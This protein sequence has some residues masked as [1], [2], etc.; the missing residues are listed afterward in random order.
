MSLNYI[1]VK[2]E[3][4]LLEL[5]QKYEKIFD[6]TLGKYTGSNYTVELPKERCKALS[7][8]AFSYSENS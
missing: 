1:M 4:I 8:T 5:F 7:C 6:R 2:H 3:K